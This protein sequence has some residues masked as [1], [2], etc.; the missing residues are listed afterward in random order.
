MINGRPISTFSF[1][2]KTCGYSISCLE[3]PSVKLGSPYKSGY[4]HV[5]F[6]IGMDI[7]L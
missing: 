2:I 4:E 6:V 7:T 1:P 3:I 5:E